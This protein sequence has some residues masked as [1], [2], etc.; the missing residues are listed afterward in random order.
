MN[1]RTFDRLPMSPAKII[2]VLVGQLPQPAG[3]NHPYS[4]M[5]ISRLTGL[6]R[7]QWARHPDSLLLGG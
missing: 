4:V 6:G 3:Q 2:R 5:L 7:E 1:V